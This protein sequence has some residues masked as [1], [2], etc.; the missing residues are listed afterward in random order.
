M[1]I[2]LTD[3]E[4]KLARKAVDILM[5]DELTPTLAFRM[6]EQFLNFYNNNPKSE[7][8]TL[9]DELSKKQIRVLQ[10]VI[11]ALSAK[12]NIDNDEIMTLIEMNG[13]K[14]RRM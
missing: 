3:G 5:S 13:G 2:P 9:M 10:D 4:E 7:N 1:N 12:H 6:S 8:Y 11:D 14:T